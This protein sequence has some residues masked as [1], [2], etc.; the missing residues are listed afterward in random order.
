MKREYTSR[1]FREG[2][3]PGLNKKKSGRRST[4]TGPLIQARASY[5]AGRIALDIPVVLVSELNDH[6]SNHWSQRHLRTEAQQRAAETVL[7]MLPR[8]VDKEP[9]L[10]DC[11]TTEFRV[12][13]TRVAPGK[14]DRGDNLNACGKW[15]RDLISRWIGVD[16]GS[17]RYAWNY[18]RVQEGKFYGCRVVI[19]WDPPVIGRTVDPATVCGNRAIRMMIPLLPGAKTSRRGLVAELHEA[20]DRVEPGRKPVLPA[21]LRVTFTRIAGT[22]I[23]EEQLR[24]GFE[25]L[26]SGLQEWLH[27]ESDVGFWY[28]YE[29][30]E[31][32]DRVGCCVDLYW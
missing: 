2:K 11:D 28:R 9:C 7:L 19:E 5:V 23:D 24:R 27:V 31:F 18:K 10:N 8:N 6:E 17:D 22:T 16:D 13:I 21:H 14:L 15:I 4:P 32:D 30:A 1:D 26:R 20:L 12:T 25:P 29:Q 3:V